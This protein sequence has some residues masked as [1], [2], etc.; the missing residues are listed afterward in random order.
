M[1]L[2]ESWEGFWQ[3]FSSEG[4]FNL[5]DV[6]MF[7]LVAFEREPDFADKSAS[8]LVFSAQLK[9]KIDKFVED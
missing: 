1:V 6:L 9:G 7:D 4:Q 3:Q 8:V 5:F 2:D